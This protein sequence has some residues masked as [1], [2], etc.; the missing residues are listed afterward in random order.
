MKVIDVYRQY[1]AASC[2][3]SGRPRRA[4]EVKLTSVSDSG[5]IS[6]AVSVNF[7]PH[8][9]E[10]DFAVSYDAYAERT[11]YDAPGRRSKKREK[12]LLAALREQADALALELDGEIRW[13]QPLREA[14]LG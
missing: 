7:F 14:Q 2:V 8:E 13:E 10:T 5:R 12:E 4:A 6:Y 1:F 3:C 9:E 11:V